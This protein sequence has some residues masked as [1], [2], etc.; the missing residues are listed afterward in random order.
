M[1]HYEQEAAHRKGE[2]VLIFRRCNGHAHA[3]TNETN[4]GPE[5]PGEA[6]VPG[7]EHAGQTAFRTFHHRE[8][9]SVVHRTVD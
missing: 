8:T 5:H 7:E 4:G 1:H 9:R 6:G 3:P 2:S